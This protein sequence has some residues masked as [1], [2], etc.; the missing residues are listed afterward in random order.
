MT[1]GAASLPPTA[2]AASASSRPDTLRLL[3]PLVI[4]EA[5]VDEAIEKIA[6]AIG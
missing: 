6:R 4:G 2:A 5:E 1:P 3:P